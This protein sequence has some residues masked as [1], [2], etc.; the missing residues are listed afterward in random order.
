MSA[1]AVYGAPV[2]TG[3][4]LGQLLARAHEDVHANGK[5]DC[6]VCGNTL[7]SNGVDAECTSC[8]SRLG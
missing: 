2:A 3:L 7:L 1:T 5:A 6:P 4:T 8:G